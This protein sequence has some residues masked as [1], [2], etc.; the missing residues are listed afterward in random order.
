MVA[1]ETNVVC[2][3]TII[4]YKQHLSRV[5]NERRVDSGLAL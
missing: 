4:R 2:L 3:F 5:S 1:V